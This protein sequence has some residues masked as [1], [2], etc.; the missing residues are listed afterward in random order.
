MSHHVPEH[1]LLTYVAG[2][3]P[4]AVALAVAGHLASCAQCRQRVDMLED[5]GGLLLDELPGEALQEGSLDAVLAR[6]DEEPPADPAP[7]PALPHFLE[8]LPI[9]GPV[10]HYLETASGW[11][12]ILPGIRAVEMPLSLE[13]V[14]VN[15]MA[16]KG[17]IT[18]PEH[19]HS[20][21][22]LNLVLTGGFDCTYDDAEYLPGDLCVRDP[23]TDHTQHI[24]K[25][26]D[27]V[28]LVVR[29]GQLLPR[30]LKGRIGQWLTG[31]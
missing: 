6:L 9:P 17:G 27:C 21:I 31:F 4:E 28:V 30:N 3:A 19:G 5:V 24:H 15:L 14:P 8:G 22:E 11:R 20:G 26:E 16:L 7:A 29:G 1:I 18:I 23:E 25:G 13:G 12:T 2:S 10:R